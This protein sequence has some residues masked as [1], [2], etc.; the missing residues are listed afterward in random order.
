LPD[1]APEL[2]DWI[3]LNDALTR[4]ESVDPVGAELTK[5]RMFAGLSVEEAGEV[6]GLSR[7]HAFRK[8][9]F[10]QAWLT[11]ELKEKSSEEPESR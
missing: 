2:D 3:D 4:F 11:S 7:A 8:W 5:L 1:A 9:S 6:L 10:S